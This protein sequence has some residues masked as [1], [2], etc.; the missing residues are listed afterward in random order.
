MVQSTPQIK[1]GPETNGGLVLK[2][3]PPQRV[4]SKAAY[5]SSATQEQSPRY[6]IDMGDE[7]SPFEELREQVRNLMQSDAYVMIYVFATFYS[8]FMDEIRV[9][10]LPMTADDTV[11]AFMFITFLLFFMEIFLLTFV[12]WD[13]QRYIGRTFFW[14]DIV[15][16]LSIT[17]DIPWMRDAIFTGDSRD[18][19]ENYSVARASRATRLGS[20]AGKL[21]HMLNFA[22]LL[23][24]LR[25]M[26]IMKAASAQKDEEHMYT[27]SAKIPRRLAKEVVEQVSR[28]VAGVVLLV[29][30]VVFLC[31]SPLQE[32]ENKLEGLN[33]LQN[34]HPN[35]TSTAT[36]VWDSSWSSAAFNSSLHLYIKG[37]PELL[38]L[39]IA[40]TQYYPSSHFVDSSCAAPHF[41]PCFFDPDTGGATT[42][43]RF[44]ELELRE[45]TTDGGVTVMYID[46]RRQLKTQARL[47]MLLISM[48]VVMLVGSAF[49]FAKDCMQ[50]IAAPVEDI[51]MAKQ[52]TEA[53]L[54]VFKIVAD[55]NDV[56]SAFCTIV[57]ALCKVLYS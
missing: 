20:R 1:G 36:R 32:S 34:L 56:N 19:L 52:T 50:T 55:E 18:E 16:V 23:R 33:L 53:L 9:L 38:Y 3:Q 43:D 39:E 57:G 30:V 13:D 15:S 17:I 47:S 11:F 40:G 37:Q 45:W 6:K 29:V 46:G 14:L 10:T 8:L 21:S 12:H 28:R 44:R 31:V 4:K 26:R 42:A 48:I 22:Q 35:A 24:V 54:D 51:V 7:P 27:R 49:I 41:V 25:A 2:G 5:R